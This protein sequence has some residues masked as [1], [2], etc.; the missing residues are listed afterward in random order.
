MAGRL[1]LPPNVYATATTTQQQTVGC[2]IWGLMIPG[3]SKDILC[4]V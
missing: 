4:H 1:G 3:L 2:G